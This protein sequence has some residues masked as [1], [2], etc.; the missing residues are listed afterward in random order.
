MSTKPRTPEHF[1]RM[2]HRA[3]SRPC[4]Q[5]ASAVRRLDKTLAGFEKDVRRFGDAAFTV[6]KH[7]ERLNEMIVFED[8][9]CGCERNTD[10]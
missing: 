3:K 9:H 8:G 10:G 2:K 7:F 1:P 4:R 6:G 5:F